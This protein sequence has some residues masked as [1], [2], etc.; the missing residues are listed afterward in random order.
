MKKNFKKYLIASAAIATLLSTGC[1][2]DQVLDLDPIASLSENTAFTTPELIANAIN[3]MYNAAQVGLYNGS[4]RGYVWGAAYIE[5]NDF[6]GED[7]V[8]TAAFFQYTYEGTYDATNTLNNVYYWVDG[9]RLINR[10][11]IV[12]N[13]V[14]GAA[15]KGIISQALADNYIGQAKFLRA[16][17]HFELL[18]QF[19]RPYSDNPTVNMG[20]PYRTTALENQAAID[21]AYAVDRSTVASTYEKV[22]A[23]LDEAE[24]KISQTGDITYATKNAAV[25][26][27][28]RV[29][30]HKRDWNG[31][32][33]EINKISSSYTLTPTPSGVFENNATNTE[34]IFSIRQSAVVNPGVNGAIGA[35]YKG[36]ALGAISPIIWNDKEW[37]EDDKRRKKSNNVDNTGDYMA[38]ETA[39][40]IFSNKYRDISTFTD[41]TPIIRFAEILL[42]QA[43]AEAR[44]NGVTQV[45]LDALNKV[46]NR[47]LTNPASQAYSL[48]SFTD[49]ASFVK[50]VIKERRIE[51]IAEGK[52][53]GDI[54]RLQNDDLAPIDGIPAKMANGNPLLTSYGYG[55]AVPN[56]STKQIP[57]S[58][59]KFIWPLPAMETD[60]NPTLKAQQNP[61]Y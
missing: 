33:N 6:R 32:L 47:A 17:T 11:N 55:Q 26:F 23:D 38:Y 58:S 28:A 53:W 3:G 52:R 16:I 31:V 2:E 13:G 27:K 19:S 41:F 60:Y 24:S 54:H 48:S 46:R 39:S 1:T 51:F 21:A 30:L 14:Q 4:G 12:I 56:Y 10:C 29:K 34:S 9:Y 35:I 5:Q 25:A 61:G 59:N 45:A 20:V 37:L 42:M 15:D 57:Y 36:R 44:L 7:M 49:K 8:N 22:L 50:A 43:E 40:G 18:M